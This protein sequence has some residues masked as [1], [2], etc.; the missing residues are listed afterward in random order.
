MGIYDSS[1]RPLQI[2]S[3]EE[4]PVII[5][6][7]P[8]RYK[9]LFPENNKL[10]VTTKELRSFMPGYIK[11]T[12]ELAEIWG[13]LDNQ[14]TLLKEYIP[15]EVYGWVIRYPNKVKELNTIITNIKGNGIGKYLPDSFVDK[16][17]L[18]KFRIK[19][20]LKRFPDPI[21]TLTKK[22]NDNLIIYK[23]M[24]EVPQI[25]GYIDEL[26]S[27]GL[28]V[29][30]LTEGFQSRGEDPTGE[31]EE[32]TEF[33]PKS[34]YEV[35]LLSKNFINFTCENAKTINPTL[36]LLKTLANKNRE[37][38]SYGI[39]SLISKYFEDLCEDKNIDYKKAVIY[40]N[41]LGK[42]IKILD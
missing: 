24:D 29:E 31:F 18:G 23:K 10:Y 8:K 33:N 14:P 4:E 25:D 26:C 13:N 30:N 35:P 5:I 9:T 41:P 32:L 39:S 19:N 20:K 1:I 11:K 16:L 42:Y 34:T 6:D 7:I 40:E 3:L 15:L 37:I 21:N 2:G 27:A 28:T 12:D 36:K 17:A 38:Y 22:R